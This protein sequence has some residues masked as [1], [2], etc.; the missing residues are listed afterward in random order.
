ATGQPPDLIAGNW[1]GNNF[2]AANATYPWIALDDLILPGWYRARQRDPA[3]FRYLQSMLDLS[4]SRHI[5]V[6]LFL[7]PA[8][9]D[10]PEPLDMAGMWEPFE[11]WKRELV[12]LAAP[13]TDGER[14]EG[15]ELWDFDDYSQ[16]STEPVPPQPHLMLHWFWNAN[17]Y[18][19]ALGDVL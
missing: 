14:H 8:H 13:Y 1:Y 3:A 17:H 19:H 2:T 9:A 7:S 4:R 15:V 6:I 16:Y 11:Q 12:A 5:R 18:T 10:E